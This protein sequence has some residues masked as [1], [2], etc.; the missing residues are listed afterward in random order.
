RGLQPI[1]YF[2]FTQGSQLGKWYTLPSEVALQ[3]LAAFVGGAKG[4][5]IYSFPLGMDGLYL[6]EL[7]RANQKIHLFERAVLTGEKAHAQFSLIPLTERHRAAE[8]RN[9]LQIRAFCVQG[10]YTLAFCNFDNSNDAVVQ[11]DIKDLEPGSYTLRDPLRNRVY[12]RG[13]AIELSLDEI[14][15]VLFLMEKQSIEFLLLEPFRPDRNDLGLPVDLRQISDRAG[16]RMMHL[17]AEFTHPA[18][19]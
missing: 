18:S 2:H 12:A 4:V 17:N 15:N 19:Q 10:A 13:E 5:F 9:W 8:S 11:L 1:P 16:Q 7:A 3:S 14:R 6:N